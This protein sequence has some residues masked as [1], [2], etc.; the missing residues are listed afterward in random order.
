MYSRLFYVSL[1]VA[2][3]EWL[4]SVKLFCN[5]SRINAFTYV[6]MLFDAHLMCTLPSRGYPLL[7]V[8][9]TP[10]QRCFQ[11]SSIALMARARHANPLPVTCQRE[12]LR[13]RGIE[14][15]LHHAGQIQ[16]SLYVHRAAAEH[17]VKM[18]A[19]H[20]ASINLRLWRNSGFKIKCVWVVKERIRR[21]CHWKI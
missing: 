7:C 12:P 20:Y 14:A 3:A 15:D 13:N 17:G 4:F 16:L 5:I 6:L 11:S 8:R 19:M 10:L 18:S 9:L 21:S 1:Y 2:G